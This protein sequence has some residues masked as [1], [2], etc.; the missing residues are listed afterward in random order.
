MTK[1]E[2]NI[3]SLPGWHLNFILYAATYFL[4]VV[5]WMMLDVTRPVD[6]NGSQ[7]SKAAAG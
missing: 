7:N 5:F 6:T 1:A 3:G 4:A 2:M